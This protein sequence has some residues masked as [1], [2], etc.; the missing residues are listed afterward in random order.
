VSLIGEDVDAE[1]GA[2]EHGGVLAPVKQRLA[3]QFVHDCPEP[4]P[5]PYCC[6]G[7]PPQVVVAAGQQIARISRAGQR[8]GMLS[9]VSCPCRLP[10]GS[11]GGVEVIRRSLFPL[12][13]GTQ[14]RDPG[15]DPDGIPSALGFDLEQHFVVDSGDP[16]VRRLVIGE[17]LGRL[18]QQR[19]ADLL[20]WGVGARD[21]QRE[22][23]T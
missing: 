6:L 15:I 9:V 19:M 3:D 21:G 23:L 1:G 4:T 22:I 17:A 11:E 18:G 16:F 14:P 2:I 13:G 5:G 20:Q 7:S 10:T 8:R 12:P